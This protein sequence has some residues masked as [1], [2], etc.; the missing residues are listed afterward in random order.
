MKFYIASRF[1]ERVFLR[2][3]RISLEM[4][5]HKVTSTWL[6]EEVDF[7]RLTRLERRKVAI[8]DHAEIKAADRLI[9]D[10]TS[11]L[12][13][14]SGGGREDEYGY[15][16]G[17]GINTIRIGPSL[18]PFHELADKEYESWSDFLKELK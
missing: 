7:D 10:T 17:R 3:V 6:D 13:E 18:N 5:G 1:S 2:L 4:R 8:R 11:P 14:G 15:A 16:N 9:L 12:H